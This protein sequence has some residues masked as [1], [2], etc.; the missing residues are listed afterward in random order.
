MEAEEAGPLGDTTDS[1]ASAKINKAES[2]IQPKQGSHITESM[3]K[4]Y[5]KCFSKE[6]YVLW[7]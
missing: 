3:N 5:G 6:M 1:N 2:N 7:R 4:G